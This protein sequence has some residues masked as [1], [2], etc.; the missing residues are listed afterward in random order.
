[1]TKFITF[2]LS[3]RAIAIVALTLTGLAAVGLTVL[4]TSPASA[5]TV[6]VG[7]PTATPGAVSTAVASTAPQA[8]PTSTPTVA[9]PQP[10]PTPSLTAVPQAGL[11][12]SSPD[13]TLQAPRGTVVDTWLRVGN[14]AATPLSVTIAPA[15]V[16]LG[17]DGVTGFTPKPDPRFAGQIT[18]SQTQA[19]IPAGGYIELAVKVSIPTTIVPDIYVLGFLI[20]PEATG[21]SV[22]IVNQIGSLIAFDVPGSRDRHLTAAFTAVPWI[23]FTNHPSLTVRTH[24]VGKSALEFTSQDALTGFGAVTPAITRND[25]RLLPSGT[26]RDLTVAWNVPWGFGVDTV[27]TTLLYP[28]TVSANAQI[29]LTHQVIVVK[30]LLALIAGAMLLLILAIIALSIVH[31]R[32]NRPVRRGTWEATN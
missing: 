13:G 27:T 12:V 2:T 32:R 5:S 17:N 3:L 6:P 9:T 23:M 22:R 4:N 31:S 10:V 26:H 1:M 14:A 11:S 29:V 15:T 28:K 19:V 7:I 24:S 25:P 8:R 20:T 16:N 18:L 21:T 30:P